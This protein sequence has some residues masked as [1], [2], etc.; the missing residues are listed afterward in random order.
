MKKTIAFG[1]RLISIFGREDDPYFDHINFGDHANDFLIKIANSYLKRE[2]VILDI[3][4]NIGVTSIIFSICAPNGRIYS[5]EP[6]PETFGFL[7]ET[8]A[9]NNAAN[10]SPY[11]LALGAKVGEL[12]FFDNPTS[13]SAS[14]LVLDGETLGGSTMSVDVST[15]D[16]FIKEKEIA[17]LDFIKIDVE[18]FELDVLDGA[19]NTLRTLKPGVFLEFN[20]FTLIAHRNLNPRSVIERLMAAFP[21]V[22][23]FDGNNGNI[24]LISSPSAMHGFIHDNLIKHS[25]VDDLFC[26]YQ[27]LEAHTLRQAHDSNIL[28]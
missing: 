21:F 14:H 24:R 22:Y 27:P 1:K 20:S 4:A 26:C 8:L 9:S 2:A 12:Q 10:C 11:K 23:A 13:A 19:A 6:S 18:G 15:V 7:C 3:G 16:R 28:L 17:R 5:F 25:C